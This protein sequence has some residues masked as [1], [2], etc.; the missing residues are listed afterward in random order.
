MAADNL[1]TGPDAVAQNYVPDIEDVLEVLPLV[2]PGETKSLLFLAPEQPGQYPY[3]CT[4]P[5]HWPMMNGTMTV[6]SH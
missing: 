1:G 6:K 2:E 4:I 5:G 3:V